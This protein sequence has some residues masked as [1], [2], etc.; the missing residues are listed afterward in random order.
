VLAGSLG[1]S[2]VGSAAA[3]TIPD[4][5]LA[6]ARLLVGAELL[7]LDF[8]GRAIA[9][10][11]LSGNALADLKRA[12]ANER[13]H[14]QSVSEILSGAGQTPAVAADFDVSYPKGTF[15]S[16]QS[17]A[18]VGVTLETVFMGAYLGAVEGLQTN[19]LRRLAARIAASE[20]EHL[21]VFMRLSGRSP[22]GVSLPR[23]LTAD[24][25]SGA[26]DAFTS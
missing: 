16:R 20:A 2:F 25:V 3:D 4:D 5:D 9:S 21:G 10:K 13:G 14:Y 1:G 11:R 17:I 23:P 24:Q 22:V 12:R 18:K 8:H 19:A 15:A 6:Y 26:L 7:A